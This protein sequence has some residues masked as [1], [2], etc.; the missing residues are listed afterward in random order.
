MTEEIQVE[1]D[2]ETCYGAQNCSLAAPGGFEYDA[3]G[4]AIVASPPQ[5]TPEQ[6]RRAED[7]CPAMAIKVLIANRKS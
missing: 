6:Y 5:A 4:K 3:D 7:E 2:H 1:V